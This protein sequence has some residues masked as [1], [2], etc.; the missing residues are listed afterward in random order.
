MRVMLVLVVAARFVD[1]HAADVLVPQTQDDKHV[2]APTPLLALT[3]TSTEVTGQSKRIP[4]CERTN[5]VNKCK[6][7]TVESE[8]DNA[9][10]EASD[11]A[12]Q[13]TDGDEDEADS[14]DAAYLKCLKRRGRGAAGGRFG[15]YW[16]PSDSKCKNAYNRDKKDQN[17][18][19]LNGYHA[20][21]CNDNPCQ[22]SNTCL[23]LQSEIATGDTV[24]TRDEA[25]Y[26]CSSD[27]TLTSGCS[28][29]FFGH[30]CDRT[31]A[32]RV[33]EGGGGCCLDGNDAQ[34]SYTD[35]GCAAK[36]ND[37]MTGIAHCTK[38]DGDANNWC[39]HT[40]VQGQKAAYGYCE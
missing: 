37:L 27:G 24:R 8:C 3:S 40:V 7:V 34:T 6:N 17:D 4:V 12:C 18:K 9:Y 2:S 36:P 15:C 11:D 5:K 23:N 21:K 14:E 25:S 29:G 28:S 39:L 1:G 31:C 32:T 10:L 38:C 33:T 22:N 16:K 20:C 26:H 35:M 13:K 19:P 30:N